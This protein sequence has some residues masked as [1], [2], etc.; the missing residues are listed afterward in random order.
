M[1]IAEYRQMMAYLMRPK[2]Q[3]GGYVRLKNGGFTGKKY[4]RMIRGPRDEKGFRPLLKTIKTPEYEKYLKEQK[5]GRKA[6]QRSRTSDIQKKRIKE[7]FPNTKFNFREYPYNGVPRS[8]PVY[9][10]IQSF[11]ST[12]VFKTGKKADLSAI[13][14]KASGRE[15][16]KDMKRY[17]KQRFPNIK[18]YEK[19]YDQADVQKVAGFKKGLQ[20]FLRLEKIPNI[21]KLGP[22]KYGD[23]AYNEKVKLLEQFNKLKP[24]LKTMGKGTGKTSYTEKPFTLEEWLKAGPERRKIGR[25]SK[26]EYLEYRGKMAKQ[27][28]GFKKLEKK[29]LTP[30]QYE[31]KYLIP[32]REQAIGKPKG[33]I[34]T[35]GKPGRSVL[36]RDSNVLLNYMTTAARK[37]EKSGNKKFIDVLEKGKFVGVKDVD[38]GVTYYHDQ[39]K[40]KLDDTKK[41]ITNHPDYENTKNL[42]KFAKRFKYSMPNETIGS[43]F[44]D[45]K[46]VPTMGELG[47]FLTRAGITLQDSKEMVDRKLKLVSRYSDQAMKTNPLHLHHTLNV[48]GAP[49][50]GIMLTLQDRN[51]LAG[52]IVRNFNEGSIDKTEATKQLK[53]INTAAILGDEVVGAKTDVA[54]ER[55]LASATKRVNKMFFDALK[56]RPDVVQSIAKKFGIAGKA[57][58]ASLAGFLSINAISPQEAVAGTGYEEEVDNILPKIAVGAGAGAA[59]IGTKTGRNILKRAGKTIFDKGIRP[60]GTRAAGS[61]LAADQVRRNIQSGENVA[62]AVVDPLVGLELSFPGLFKENLAKITTNPTAQRILNLGRFARLTTPVG[63]GIT[64][65]GLAVDVGKAIYKRKQLLDSMTPTQKDVFLAQEYEDL[66]G[67]AGEGAAAGGLIGKKS[68]PPPESGPTPQGLDYLIK[69]G[70]RS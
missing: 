53:K 19:F 20:T 22:M 62:D 25:F 26:E 23:G 57:T 35:I 43:Y 65:A 12:S 28:K 6:E 55:Q 30:Q 14:K 32:G 1:K 16:T 48:E 24:T 64:A 50:K 4:E 40:G 51:D 39:Y 42:K 54:P 67:I 10:Q 46:R 2:Y 52:K 41:L 3:R 29:R 56:Q 59:A 69:R 34:S 21:E 47:N 38:S 18:D 45:Y 8:S 13:Q 60:L 7:R 31:E 5:A 11:R 9:S 63:L 33:S 17:L 15:L 70:R 36:L 49:T 37:Q 61:L 68:G 27:A 58:A 44:A 66:G